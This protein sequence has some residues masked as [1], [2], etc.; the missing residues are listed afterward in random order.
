MQL[1]KEYSLPLAS[2]FSG[3]F[4]VFV[5]QGSRGD[6]QVSVYKKNGGMV[7][8]FMKIKDVVD[9]GIFQGGENDFI[10]YAIKLVRKTY[11]NYTKSSES[12]TELMN[13]YSS[14]KTEWTPGMN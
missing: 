5:S 7:K 3:L 2:S 11:R 8:S 14:I 6:F 4:Q 13:T 12:L 9:F 10:D 1:L